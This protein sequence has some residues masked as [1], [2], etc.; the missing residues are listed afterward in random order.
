MT[1]SPSLT[2]ESDS[3]A[4][5]VSK[6]RKLTP[7]AE[8]PDGRKW[9]NIISKKIA[10]KYYDLVFTSDDPGRARA[11][12]K[13]AEAGAAWLCNFPACGVIIHSSGGTGNIGTHYLN[14]H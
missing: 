14:K 2:L 13:K 3:L 1:L 7:A 4:D 11:N 12:K 5:L 10:A 8:T 9:Y 6:R